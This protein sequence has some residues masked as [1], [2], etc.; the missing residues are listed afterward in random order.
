MNLSASLH[1]AI[2]HRRNLTLCSD[3][4][5]LVNGAGDDLEGLLIDRYHRHFQVQALTEHWH[6]NRL[7]IGRILSSCFPVDYLI[8]KSRRGQE[9]REEV[10][11]GS[12]P[13]TVVH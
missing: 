6:K 10:L 3:A 4:M 8:V 12:S 9:I 11:A 2:R 7:E 1:K 5:R 13:Q